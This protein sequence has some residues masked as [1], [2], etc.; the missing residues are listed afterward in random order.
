M[1][2]AGG[3]SGRQAQKSLGKPGAPGWGLWG[4]EQLW[5]GP[6][7]KARQLPRN[8]GPCQE[9]CVRARRLTAAAGAP[10]RRGAGVRGTEDGAGVVSRNRG[11]AGAGWVVVRE[12]WSREG[13][14]Q[15]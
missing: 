3:L 4:Q 6:L 11:R 13:H 1:S 9:L 7:G 14:R 5:G 8:E 2:T 15:P 12:A 10:T